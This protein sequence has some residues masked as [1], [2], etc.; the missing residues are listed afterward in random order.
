MKVTVKKTKFIMLL[1]MFFFF[2]FFFFASASEDDAS[3]CANASFVSRRERHHT[4][5]IKTK[6]MC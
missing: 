6:T 5:T 1:C 4:I 3:P 2:F